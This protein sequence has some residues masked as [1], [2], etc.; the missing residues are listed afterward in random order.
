MLRSPLEAEG[1]VP[2]VDDS[3]ARRGLVL[4]GT[5]HLVAQERRDQMLGENRPALERLFSMHE[6]LFTP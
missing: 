3:P 1:Q 5:L 2:G 4:C 6:E